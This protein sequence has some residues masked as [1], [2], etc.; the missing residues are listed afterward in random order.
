MHNSGYSHWR[1][2]RPAFFTWREQWC[3]LVSLTIYRILVTFHIFQANDNRW[4]RYALIGRGDSYEWAP[5]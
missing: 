4:Q 2:G 3:L 5:M 1:S